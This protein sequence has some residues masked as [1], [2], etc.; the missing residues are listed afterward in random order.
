MAKANM[1]LVEA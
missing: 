1:K